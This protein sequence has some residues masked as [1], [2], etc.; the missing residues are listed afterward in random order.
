MK[1][2]LCLVLLAVFATQAFPI[3]VTLKWDASLEPDIDHYNLKWGFIQGQ[4]DHVINAGSGISYTVVEPWSV[5]MTIYFVCT[6]VNVSNLESGP[7]NE[8]SYMVTPWNPSAPGHLSIID[9]T[10]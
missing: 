3:S 8:V 9:V 6:A 7:S 10:K 1:V 2:I 5:G 4:E